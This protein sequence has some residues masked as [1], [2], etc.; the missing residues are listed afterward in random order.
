[1][2]LPVGLPAS[3]SVSLPEEWEWGAEPRLWLGDGQLLDAPDSCWG[4]AAVELTA[5]APLTGG[6]TPADAAVELRRV[7]GLVVRSLRA[8]E[9]AGALEL[10]YVWSGQG[11]QGVQG[12]QSGQGG[13]GVQGGQGGRLRVLLIARAAGRSLAS[14]RAW[15]ARMLENVVAFFPEGTAFGPVQAPLPTGVGAWAEVERV[16]EVRPP[17]PFVPAETASYY[18]LVH[19]LG[20]SGAGWPGLPG[21][22]ARASAPGFLSVVLMPTA[23]TGLEQAAVDHVCTLARYLSE[24]QQGYDFFGQQRTTPADAAAREVL[25]AWQRF[26]TR[27][28]VLARIGISAAPDDLLRLASLTGSVVTDASDRPADEL[29]TRFRTVVVENEFDVY[30]SACLGFVLPRGTHPVWSLPDGQAPYALERMPYFYGEDEAAALLVLPVPDEQGVPGL[31]R[32]R[33]A[34]ARRETVPERSEE[35]PDVRLGEALHRGAVGRPVSVPLTALNRHTLVVGASG[36]GKTTTVLTLLA[37]LWREHRVPFLVVEPSKTEYRSLLGAPGFAELRIVSLGRDDLAPLRLNPLAPPPGVRREVHANAVMSVLKL[38]LPLAPPLPQLLEE[39]LD[40]AYDLAGWGFDTVAE[41]GLAPPTLRSLLD[42]LD[43]VFEQQGY[44]GEARNVGV[45]LSVRLRSL[46]RGSRGRV[47][48]TVESVDFAELMDRPV[49]VELDQI[50]DHDDKLVFA[51]LLLDRVRAHARGRGSTSGRLAHVTVLE[52]AHRLLSR[53]DG[54]AREAESGDR[55]RSATV[56][57]FCDAIAELR[58]VG[59]GFVLSSQSP[60]AL[61]EAAVANTGVRLL[62]RMESAADRAAVLDDLGAGEA[63]RELA[64]RL[65]TGEALTRWPGADEAEL[66]LVAPQ[67]G[68]DSGRPVDDP[69][70]RQRM[71]EHTDRVRKLMPHPLCGRSLCPAGCDPGVRGAGQALAVATGT[72]ARQEWDAARGS[73]AAVGPIMDLLAARAPDDARLTY[74]AAVHLAVAGTAL[75]VPGRGDLRPQLVRA[76]REAVARR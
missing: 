22:L 54:G 62:H 33:S 6:R 73:A 23:M 69:E 18:Y 20:G 5:A 45:A 59:E 40:H 72:A 48:D 74:C 70:V 49:V 43:T 25:L 63:D 38:A 12:S 8:W 39:A 57:G 1:V 16:E 64:A 52:E 11:G 19:P 32:A 46:L 55:L 26:S 44:Q 53:A 41:D 27:T 10:R 61:A 34:G 66:V 42:A 35:G 65:R 7:A 58:S 3:T 37:G 2:N 29:P 36:S 30:Q 50:S 47:L 60:G 15:A 56:R 76:A 28:G 67:P 75:R 31:P 4:A 17:G 68:V 71:A 9:N 21:A 13:Q 51:A 14:A 24:P